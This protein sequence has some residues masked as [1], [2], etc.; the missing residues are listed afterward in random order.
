MD[1]TGSDTVYRGEEAVRANYYFDTKIKK[2]VTYGR[3]TN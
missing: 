2:Q 3:D 1:E